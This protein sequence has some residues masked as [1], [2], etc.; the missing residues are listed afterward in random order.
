MAEMPEEATEEELQSLREDLMN[1]Y[2]K[3]NT[4]WIQSV[5][6]IDGQTLITGMAFYGQES[7]K[8]QISPF[9]KRRAAFPNTLIL[10]QPGMGKTRMAR[11]IADQRALNFLELLCPANPDDLPKHGIVLLDECHRQRHPEWL[12][13]TME[14]DMVSVLGATTRPELLDSAFKSRFMLTLHLKRYEEEAMVEMALAIMDLSPQASKIY[15]R[16]SAG[17]PRQLEMILAVA[18]ELGPLNVVE[19]LTSCRIT[20][21]G[22]TEY[23]L[24][25][26]RA[27]RKVGRPIGVSTLASM[28]F[29]DEA[30]IKEHEQLLVE[31]E[32]MDLRPNGRELSRTGKTYLEALEQTP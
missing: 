10:G 24:D 6:D 22:L 28:L 27:L 5:R 14:N 13:A 1:P 4:N 16:A 2:D 3:T 7:A 9:L 18:Q 26:L 17:N 25:V 32:L 20:I 21:D 30:S 19:V 29:S 31:L 11:W 8:S 12:F 23:H 15:A